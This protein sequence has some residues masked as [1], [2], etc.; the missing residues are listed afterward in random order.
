ME[1]ERKADPSL[2][3]NELSDKGEDIEDMIEEI[4]EAPDHFL[5]ISSSENENQTIQLEKYSANMDIFDAS[6]KIYGLKQNTSTL[7]RSISVPLIN[8]KDS[9]KS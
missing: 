9:Y 7:K 2:V 3:L 1:N 6:V 4:E 8:T 5:P